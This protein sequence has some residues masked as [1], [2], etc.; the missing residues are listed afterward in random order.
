MFWKKK[1]D[2]EEKPKKKKKKKLVKA[3]EEA[4]QAYR[5][6]PSPDDP[7]QFQFGGK[8][9]SAS[10]ISTG[11]ISFKNSHFAQGTQQEVKFDLPGS[12]TLVQ[13]SL[14]LLRI[15]EAKNLCCCRFV[16][17]HPDH[18]DAINTYVLQRQKEELQSKK[19]YI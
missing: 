19:G 18:E 11:G 6:A 10:D 3:T 13:T 5:V 7:I 9:V 2:S 12:G 16:D 1:K 8:E 4:R 15:I 14:K 17:L